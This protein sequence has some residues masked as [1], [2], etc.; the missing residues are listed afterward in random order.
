MKSVS[1][2]LSS[3]ICS[4]RRQITALAELVHELV[5]APLAITSSAEAEAVAALLLAHRRG[6]AASF[7]RE[8]PFAA[9]L[10]QRVLGRCNSSRGDAPLEQPDTGGDRFAHRSRGSVR[11]TVT[12]RS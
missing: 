9:R 6:R 12:R 11:Q 3:E 1:S 5:P 7:R 10:V 2:R 8:R 4:L